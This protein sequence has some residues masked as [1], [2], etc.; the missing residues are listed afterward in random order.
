MYNKMEKY[1]FLENEISRLHMDF[2]NIRLKIE[3]DMRHRYQYKKQYDEQCLIIHNI[4]ITLSQKKSSC[5][6]KIEQ[7]VPRYRFIICLIDRCLFKLQQQ[8]II[9]TCKNYFPEDL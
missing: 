9:C 6:R 8:Q 7:D 4:I 3:E 2:L 1:I 5:W